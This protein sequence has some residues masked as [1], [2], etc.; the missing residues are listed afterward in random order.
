MIDGSFLQ[1]LTIKRRS[2]VIEEILCMYTMF[3]F[4]IVVPISDLRYILRENHKMGT[5]YII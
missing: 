2:C 3:E 5:Q 4:K 1:L